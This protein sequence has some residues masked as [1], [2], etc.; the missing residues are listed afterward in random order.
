MAHNAFSVMVIAFQLFNSLKGIGWTFKCFNEIPFHSRLIKDG[1]RETTTS[2]RFQTCP[3]FQCHPRSFHPS[4]AQNCKFSIQ[5]FQTEQNDNIVNCYIIRL[6]TALV[7]VCQL[8]RTK[9]HVAAAG[10]T[11]LL[12]SLNL[13]NVINTADHLSILGRSN[14]L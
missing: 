7:P 6:T 3:T 8:W 5:Q 9:V 12:P 4:P 2:G 13:V 11:P 14:I 1:R 10:L